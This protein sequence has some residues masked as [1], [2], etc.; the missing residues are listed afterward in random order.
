M[1]TASM[2]ATQSGLGYAL[3]TFVEISPRA[4]LITASGLHQFS[5]MWPCSGLPQ[6]VCVL[7]EFASNGDLVDVQWFDAESGLDIAEPSGI[8]GSA[9]LALSHDA[10]SFATI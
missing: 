6:D 9:L 8:D 10:Q 7:F 1:S 4:V 2:I 3:N 5:R